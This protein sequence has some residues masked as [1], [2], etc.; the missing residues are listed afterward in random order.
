VTTLALILALLLPGPTAAGPPREPTPRDPTAREVLAGWDAQRAAAW[1][2][3]DVRR[4]RSLYVPGSVAGERDAAMLRRWTGRGLVVTGMRV[5]VLSLQVV[6]RTRDRLVVD[7]VD[8]V[9]GAETT[10]VRLPRDQPT[11]HRLVFRFVAGQ[12]VLAAVAAG[13]S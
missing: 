13:A 9:V 1:A 5:Q 6:T 11:A 12:W 2:A 7:V 10:G 3:G 8:R 4:L